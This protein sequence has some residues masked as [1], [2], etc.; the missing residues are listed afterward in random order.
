MSNYEGFT[1]T[2]YFTVTDPD[3]LREIVSSIKWDDEDTDGFFVERDGTFAFGQCSGIKGLLSDTDACTADDEDHA[4]DEDWDDDDDDRYNANDVY[5]ALGSVVAPGDAII[6]TEVGHAD[7][8]L[9][10]ARSIIITCD[11]IQYVD[12]RTP[13][14]SAAREALCRPD[15]NPRMDY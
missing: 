10:I 8:D 6:I 4:A 3:R 14:I 9:V 5:T 11:T 15:Y 7:Y 13:A 1:R 12:L 2:N